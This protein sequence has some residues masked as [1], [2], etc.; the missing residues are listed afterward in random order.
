MGFIPYCVSM[1]KVN[2]I[3]LTKDNRVAVVEQMAWLP[4]RDS[5]R[6]VAGVRM[7]RSQ[8]RLAIVAS[9]LRP[10]KWLND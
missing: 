1:I 4:W 9:G 2:D 6:W 7:Y 5:H 3:V 10:H 8:E